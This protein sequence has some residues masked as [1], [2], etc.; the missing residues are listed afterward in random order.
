MAE[1]QE[2]DIHLNQPVLFTGEKIESA[3][4]AMILIH[5]RGSTAEDILSLSNEFIQPGFLY[6]A[7][8]AFGNTWYPY[9]FLHPV[10]ENEPGLSSGLNII[11]MLVNKIFKA[12]ISLE[13]VILLGFSQGACLVLEYAARNAKKYGGVIG[14]SGGLIGNKINIENYR[15]TFEQ[16]SVFLGCSDIDPHIPKERVDETEEIIKNMGGNVT[17]RI[18]KNMGHTI[19]IDEISFVQNLINHLIG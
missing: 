15:G 2:K 6:A 11:D 17:K 13:K 3:S 12:G 18:Y 8:Q 19:N 16:T 4:A 14:F 10:E 1:L 5:G 7:P 9:S